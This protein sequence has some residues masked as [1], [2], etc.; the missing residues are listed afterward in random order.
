MDLTK[1]NLLPLIT[2]HEERVMGTAKDVRLPRIWF[3][4]GSK[5]YT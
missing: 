2:S 4:L 1:V 5:V 3:P